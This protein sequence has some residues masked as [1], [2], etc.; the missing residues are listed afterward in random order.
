MSENLQLGINVTMAVFG[1]LL[2][3]AIVGVIVD[4]IFA[5]HDR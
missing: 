3:I 5:R 1:G 4:R 2:L